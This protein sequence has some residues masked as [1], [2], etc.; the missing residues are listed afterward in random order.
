MLW[1]VDNRTRVL[2]DQSVESEIFRDWLWNIGSTLYEL[3]YLTHLVNEGEIKDRFLIDLHSPEI[4][5][6]LDLGKRTCSE[7]RLKLGSNTNLAEDTRNE[8][9]GI[10]NRYEGLIN[11]LHEKWQRGHVA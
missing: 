3:E 11:E 1:L 6:V 4:I 10:L 2:A 5:K 8:F 9:R 7:F